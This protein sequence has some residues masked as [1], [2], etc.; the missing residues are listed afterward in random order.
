MVGFLEH[1]RAPNMSKYSYQVGRMN[2]CDSAFVVATNPFT[3]RIFR[4]HQMTNLK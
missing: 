2:D 4:K 3:A 1:C